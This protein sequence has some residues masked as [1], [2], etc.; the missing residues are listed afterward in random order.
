[1]REDLKR[2]AMWY[3]TRIGW[4]VAVAALESYR[5]EW[6]LLCGGYEDLRDDLRTEELRLFVEALGAFEESRKPASPEQY[7]S[8]G[9]A[10][11]IETRVVPAYKAALAAIV[12]RQIRKALEGR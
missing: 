10:N 7:D 5:F 2:R 6:S 8:V 1:M 9:R 3:F 11:R 12:R 4:H